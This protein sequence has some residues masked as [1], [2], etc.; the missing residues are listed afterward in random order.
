MSQPRPDTP[1]PLL[2]VLPVVTHEYA[3]PCINSILRPQSAA[4]LLPEEILI[5]DNTREGSCD[6]G[7]RTYRD[8]DGHN[9]G[10]ARAWNVGAREVLERGLDYLVI[11][12]A[13]LLFGP[14]LH[15]A[16]TWQMCEFWG[17]KVIECEG[18]SWKLIALHRSCF[19]KIGLFDSNF[20]PG[21]QESID[22]CRRLH[23]VG[24]E[25]GFIRAWCNV[26]AQTV[27]YHSN[28]VRS[29]P[30]MEYYREKWGGPKGYETFVL[31]F[32]NKPLDYFEDVPI[33]ELARRCE[34]DKYG[35][36]WW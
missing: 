16:W 34:L 21:Y 12:S 23:I 33:P 26:M 36:R 2:A 32:G 29:A 15:T 4:G 3:T 14:Q 24:W 31:P 18:M 25:Q 35:I 7:L 13:S 9:I 1:L 30:L 10:V 5:V 11:M 19:E 27:G 6:Y 22:W 8:P 28:M 17:A 20:W